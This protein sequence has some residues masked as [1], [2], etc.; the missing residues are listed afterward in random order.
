MRRAS[1][2]TLL[3]LWALGSWGTDP[4]SGEERNCRR[5]SL[6]LS[7]GKLRS[8]EVGDCSDTIVNRDRLEAKSPPPMPAWVDP[9]S[10]EIRDAIRNGEKP[11]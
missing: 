10:S 3:G 8:Q 2:V 5:W 7:K 4:A 1:I 6:Q 9:I 11:S